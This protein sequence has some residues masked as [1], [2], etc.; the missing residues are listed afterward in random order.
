MRSVAITLIAVTAGIG[1]GFALSPATWTVIAASQQPEKLPP[2][3]A[4]PTLLDVTALVEAAESWGPKERKRAAAKLDTLLVA[5]D[6]EVRVRAGGPGDKVLVVAGSFGRVGTL[7]LAKQFDFAA[8]Q[9]AGFK[10]FITESGD[11]ANGYIIDLVPTEGLGAPLAKD[12][13]VEYTRTLEE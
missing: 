7:K 3:A 13:L 5:N 8:L 12:P 6:Y 4:E 2:I 1:A 10:L 9:H 11:N